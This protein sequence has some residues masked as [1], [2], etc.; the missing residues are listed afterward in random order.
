MRYLTCQL[1]RARIF[2]YSSSEQQGS[3]PSTNRKSLSVPIEDPETTETTLARADARLPSSSMRAHIHIHTLSLSLSVFSSFVS[4]SPRAHGACASRWNTLESR[5]LFSRSM[6]QRSCLQRRIGYFVSF[7]RSS[8]DLEGEGNER[9]AR[10]G[11]WMSYWDVRRVSFRY[12]KFFSLARCCDDDTCFS[13]SREWE[14]SY[15]F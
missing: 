1:S 14:E 13:L 7:S 4:P 11:R 6:F 15:A 5:A 12:L 10:T 2:S 8:K 9:G 3:T